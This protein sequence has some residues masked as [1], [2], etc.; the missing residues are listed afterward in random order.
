MNIRTTTVDPWRC[1]WSSVFEMYLAMEIEW[2]LRCTW[3]PGLCKFGDTL[4]GLGRYNWVMNF[5]AVMERVWRCTWRPR[6]STLRSCTWRPWST[7]FGDSL[8]GYDRA[9]LEMHLQAMIERDW[10]GR[11]RWSIWREARRQLRLYSLVNLE[12]WECKELSTTS[13]ERWET[14]WE[15]ETVDFGMML[16][17]VYAVLCVN[18]WLWHGEIERDD[19]TSCS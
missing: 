9:S 7:E 10:R 6:S 1:T 11:W 3:R 2:T 18:S 16:Y 5:E 17:W 14:G 15:R 4:G 12:L 13:A 19:L 8:C